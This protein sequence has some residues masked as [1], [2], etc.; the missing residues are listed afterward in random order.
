MVQLQ[1]IAFVM[2]FAPVATAGILVG[3]GFVFGSL[4]VDED[5]EIE[6]LDLSEHSESAYGLAGAPWRRRCSRRVGRSR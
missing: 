2:G 1:G 5:A 3:L 6:G 4:R